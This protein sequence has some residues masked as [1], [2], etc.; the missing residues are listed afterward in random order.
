MDEPRDLDNAT[1]E[2]YSAAEDA[3]EPTSKKL[4]T[5]LDQEAAGDDADLSDSQEEVENELALLRE[6]EA[7][8]QQKLAQKRFEAE[9]KARLKEAALREAKELALKEAERKRA[10]AKQKKREEI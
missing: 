7:Q 9:E 3:L 1:A 4:R 2:V 6:Q 10:E 8:L 5:A